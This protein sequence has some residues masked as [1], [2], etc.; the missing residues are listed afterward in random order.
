MKRIILLSAI[1]I[2][3]GIKTFA[4][5]KKIT[6]N[7]TVIF[8]A[9][10]PSFEK[11]K[12]TNKFV[13]CILNMNTGEIAS[14]I[15]MKGF[16]FKIALMEEHFNENY[17]ES[18]K[19][20]KATFVGKIQNFSWNEIGSSPKEFKMIGKM[21]LHGITKE[22][23]TIISLRKIDESLEIITDFNL[24]YEDFNIEIPNVL[25]KKISKTVA[26]KSVFLV[27]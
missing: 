7:G 23:S 6:R 17:I 12:A 11:I 20:P 25:T 9:S 26:V 24:N 15:L 22:I 21:E 14:L 18:D 2:L 8:E 16:R 13:T 4:Q 1:F 10:V 5:E 27:K 19:F 3:I